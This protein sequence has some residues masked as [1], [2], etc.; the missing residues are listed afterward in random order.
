MGTALPDGS[1]DT[2]KKGMGIGLTVSRT[3]IEAQASGS[4][5]RTTLMAAQ[6]S[7]LPCL[8]RQ[9]VRFTS[10]SSNDLRP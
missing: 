2:K 9:N 7:A 6:L 3:I 10:S 5:Q 8:C 1:V 4:G